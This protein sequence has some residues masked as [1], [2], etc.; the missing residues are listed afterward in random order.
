MKARLP[1]TIRE[2]LGETRKVLRQP[3]LVVWSLFVICFPFYVGPPGLPQP[4]DWLIVIL[5]PMLMTRWNG[6]LPP[7]MARPFKLLLVFTAYGLLINL[8]WTFALGAFSIN[9]KKGFLLS[10]TFYIYNALM[11]FSFLLM[12][13]RFGTWFLW[14]TSRVALISVLLQL[15]L[16]GFAKSYTL[17]SQ[18][19]FNS[20]NQLGYY[21]LLIAC[22]LLLANQKLKLRTLY[23]T[24]GLTA[25]CYL[26]L[27][28]ASKA[29]L[30]SIVMLG[31][32]LMLSRVR[33]MVIATVVL[34]VLTFTE[35]PFSRAM[36]KAQLRIETDQTHG[37]LEERGYDR[38]V[39]HPEYW[40][41]G[42]GE[43]GY[44]RFA[45]TTIIGAHELHSSAA[46]LLF[47]YGII[48]LGLFGGFVWLALRNTGAR[49]MVIV[50]PAFAYGMVHQGLRFTMMWVLIGMVMALKHAT[51]ARGPPAP[52]PTPGSVRK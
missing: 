33:T 29:A 1:A 3:P 12:Y 10:P 20:P 9:L 17:R 8:M 50:I 25:C 4:A 40:L 16:T 46:T 32:A 22:I 41:F 36:E 27:M 26:A 38:V 5:L 52:A 42:S 7:G 28:S 48:G 19:F 24:I 37:L 43:G 30:G 47:S 45:D 34:L 49:G 6:R 2:A 44:M 14:V 18:L 35:N 21:A 13:Q 11:L 39:A 51:T 15:A 31:I 23:T